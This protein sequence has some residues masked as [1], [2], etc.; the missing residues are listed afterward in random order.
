MMLITNRSAYVISVMTS[1]VYLIPAG[2][3][4]RKTELGA[5][6][7]ARFQFRTETGKIPLVFITLRTEKNKR[8]RRT[9][10]RS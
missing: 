7:T 9:L 2:R 1:T 5:H 3:V 10:K 8:N 4:K 6:C